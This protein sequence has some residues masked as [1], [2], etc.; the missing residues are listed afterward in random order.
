MSYNKYK[1][2]YQSKAKNLETIKNYWITDYNK[3]F[4]EDKEEKVALWKLDDE[5]KYNEKSYGIIQA[6]KK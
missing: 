6:R 5:V 3:E 2:Y 4:D 1:N